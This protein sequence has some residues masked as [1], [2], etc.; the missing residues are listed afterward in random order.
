MGVAN[1]TKLQYNN[2][3]C[4]ADLVCIVWYLPTIP[5]L[6]L[7][8]QYQVVHRKTVLDFHCLPFYHI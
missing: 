3:V 4:I 2:I 5:C 7:L 1:Q 6:V 8:A